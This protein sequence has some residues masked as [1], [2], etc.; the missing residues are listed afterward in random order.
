MPTTY[1]GVQNGLVPITNP[2][3]IGYPTPLTPG[4]KVVPSYEL[5]TPM[6][7]PKN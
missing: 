7:V 3:T 4:P 1:N 2:P 5:P 6:P